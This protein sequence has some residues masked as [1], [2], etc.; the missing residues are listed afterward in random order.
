MQGKK[1]EKNKQKSYCVVNHCLYVTFKF[2]SNV[3]VIS[4]FRE[5]TIT[6]TII[7]NAPVRL[8]NNN[9]NMKSHNRK[10][11]LI[12]P[13]PLSHTYYSDAKTTYVLKYASY[14]YMYIQFI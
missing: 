2:H 12:K 14:K 7:F 4:T 8:Y 1:Q 5:V 6:K 11:Y 9:R 3:G 13:T 10:T